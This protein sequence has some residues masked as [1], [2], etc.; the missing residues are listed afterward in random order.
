M[1]FLLDSAAI[2]S[3]A[4]Y[5]L[6]VQP[7]VFEKSFIEAQLLVDVLW[8]FFLQWWLNTCNRNLMARKA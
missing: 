4:N 5:S 2:D 7:P 6:S 1:W 8:L 3:T